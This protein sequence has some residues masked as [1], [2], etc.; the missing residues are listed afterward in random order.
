[1]AWV[2]AEDIKFYCH[3]DE[4]LLEA[5]IRVGK[6]H[7][8]ACKEGYCG[9]CRISFKRIEG[10]RYIKEPLAKIEKDEV[11]PCIC[12]VDGYVEI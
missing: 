5:L 3:F 7:E 10:Y 4:T 9:F 12:I 6:P 11:L 2:L 8:F 1:M